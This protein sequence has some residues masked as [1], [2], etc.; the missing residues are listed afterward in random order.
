VSLK[1]ELVE[2]GKK[3]VLQ[4]EYVANAQEVKEFMC[5]SEFVNTMFLIESKMKR[6]AKSGFTHVALTAP[7]SGDP[8]LLLPRLTFDTGS[9][10]CTVVA[11]IKLYFESKAV[12][13]SHDVQS[14]YLIL[15]W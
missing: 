2:L 4:S 7:D 13:F 14:G 11:A 15:G 9:K 3:I 1:E 6:A 5:T 10:S 8:E 12:S